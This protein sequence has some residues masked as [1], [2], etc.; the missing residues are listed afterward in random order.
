MTS[1]R[2]FLK[3]ASAAALAAPAVH[4]LLTWAADASAISLPGK[5]GMIVR[6]YRF[7]DLE[8]PVEFMT[9]WITPVNHFFVRNHMFEPAKIEAGT[10][11]LTIGGEVEKP[12]TLTL[13]DLEKVPVH[14]VTNAMECAGNGR[15]LHNPKVPGIQWGKG[16]VGNAKFSG[17]SLKVILEKAGLKD[18]GKHVMFRGLDEVPGK[19]PPFIRSIPIEK[20]IDADTLIATYMNGAPLSQHHGFPARIVTPG[21]A[22]AASCKWLTEIT[23]LDKPA[24]G[25]FMTPGYRMPNNPVKP[26]EAVKPEDTHSVTGLAVKSL[27][28]AP[29]DGAKLKPG[30]QEIKGV[31]WAGEVDITKVEVSTDGGSSWTP[32]E[33]GKDHAK[34]AWRL[35]SHAWKPAK[36]GDYVI[37]SRAT[38]SQGRV[39]PDAAVWNPSGYLYNAH[40]QVKVYVQ[41]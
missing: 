21:W 10:W 12:L 9:D 20:A 37:L 27:I 40:D 30:K 32:A 17:P 7:L 31:A 11:K 24:E 23:V 28:A 1:R 8:T 33:L 15:S 35:W 18:T 39:Q 5:D 4:P 2:A 38:D 13:A 3:T 6:S 16:A 41:A 19:V 25:N 29:S 22:G 34:Y 36:S 14:S 26:G